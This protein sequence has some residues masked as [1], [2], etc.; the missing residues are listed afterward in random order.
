M[1]GGRGRRNIGRFRVE[2]KTSEG[3]TMKHFLI[4]GIVLSIAAALT[5]CL[6]TADIAAV[7]DFEPERYMGKWYEIARLPQYFE[8]DLDG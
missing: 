6:T 5:G 3:E 1:T 2:L 8:R 4:S 7:Q